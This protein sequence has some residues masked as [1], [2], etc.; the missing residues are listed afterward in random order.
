MEYP[1]SGV[2]WTSTQKRSAQAPDMY[3]DISIERD[4]LLSLIEEAGNDTSV[5][6]KLDGWR[7]KDRNNNAMVSLKVNTYKKQDQAPTQDDG[8]DP[9]DD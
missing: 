5:K 3:G 2:L 9:W 1:N 7:R 8:K 4:L 6:I